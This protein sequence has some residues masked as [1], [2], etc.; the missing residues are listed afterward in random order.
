MVFFFVILFYVFLWIRALDQK[1]LEKK[2]LS[3][4]QEKKTSDTW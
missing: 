2:T 1:D 3:M 4:D